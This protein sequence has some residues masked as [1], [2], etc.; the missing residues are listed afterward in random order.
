[1][2]QMRVQ[3]G[4]T[5]SNIMDQEI[6][7]ITKEQSKIDQKQRIKN[8]VVLN[9]EAIEYYGHTKKEEEKKTEKIKMKTIPGT[10]L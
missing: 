8:K 4:L 6:G 7:N 3:M 9:Y 10:S 5:E 2:V 1:M